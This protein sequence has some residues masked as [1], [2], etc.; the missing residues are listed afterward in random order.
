MPMSW[1]V[2]RA[3]DRA[4]L[5]VYPT[6]AYLASRDDYDMQISLLRLYVPQEFR[7]KEQVKLALL[8]LTSLADKYNIGIWLEASK[9]RMEVDPTK[10]MSNESLIAFYQ[11]HGFV[12]QGTDTSN[13]M[14]RP[15]R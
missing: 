14:F 13:T 3:H 2:D 4:E 9:P 5:H 11:K 10:T 15:A 1:S 7:R 8:T 12:R 6:P